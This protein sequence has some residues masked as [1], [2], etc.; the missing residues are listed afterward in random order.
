MDARMDVMKERLR[1]LADRLTVRPPA[2]R[3]VQADDPTIQLFDEVDELLER[4]RELTATLANGEDAGRWDELDAIIGRLAL[5]DVG[6]AVTRLRRLAARLD[7]HLM[8]AD[9]EVRPLEEAINKIEEKLLQNL[10]R[11]AEK[12]S[13]TRRAR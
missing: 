6:R 10:L 7:A 13:R 11:S 2:P 4:A 5:R 12:E 1:A 9:S 8:K 3:A